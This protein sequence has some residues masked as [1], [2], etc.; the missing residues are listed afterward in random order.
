MNF[1][2]SNYLSIKKKY[3]EFLKK[4]E[5]NG[6]PIVDIVGKFN[7]FYLPLSDWIYSTYKKDDKIKIIG[8][9]GGQGAG[10]STI[11][12]ILKLI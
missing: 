12:G 11:T 10:K 9:S 7:S 4:K 8:L 2:G 5:K 1:K 3:L 6:K